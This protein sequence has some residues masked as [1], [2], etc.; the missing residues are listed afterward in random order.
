MTIAELK[1]ELAKWPDDYEVLVN[2]QCI[3]VVGC[4]EGRTSDGPGT[5]NIQGIEE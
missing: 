1:L 2:F 4:I 5:L 3:D